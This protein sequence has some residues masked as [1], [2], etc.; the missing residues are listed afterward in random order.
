MAEGAEGAGAGAGWREGRGL[1]AA[2][3]G[4]KDPLAVRGNAGRRGVGA[5]PSPSPGSLGSPS[6][7]KR[8]R[9]VKDAGKS[10]EGGVRA[11]PA[12]GGGGGR[13]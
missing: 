7:R 8:R 5:A 2:E 12:A 3:Q 4:P 9:G 1:G 13:R 6:K 10:T 11:S